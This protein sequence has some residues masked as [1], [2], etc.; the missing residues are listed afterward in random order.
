MSLE[1]FL[2][3]L[4]VAALAFGFGLAVASP[5]RSK[6]ARYGHA[7]RRPVCDGAAFAPDDDVADLGPD[8]WKRKVEQFMC[9][10][11]LGD[12]VLIQC[13]DAGPAAVYNGQTGAL[14]S[15]EGGWIVV[16]LDDTQHG[17][18]ARFRPDE[19]RPL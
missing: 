19:L 9:E 11:R 18:A 2:H 12:R 13:V 17:R 7:A 4:A 16:A 6:P 14:E 3:A 10:G 8:P 1:T 5:R 15:V